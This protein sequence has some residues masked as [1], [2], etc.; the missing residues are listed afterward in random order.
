M[1]FAGFFRELD[2]DDPSDI[3]GRRLADAVGGDVTYS[4]AE[5]LHYL[6]SG[7]PIL[8]VMES[9][10][11]PLEP[12]LSVR[13]G[14]SLLTDG[15]WVWRH[16]LA[17]YVRRYGVDLPSAFLRRMGAMDHTIPDVDVDALRA[18]SLEVSARLGHT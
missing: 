7:Y 12:D 14:P 15:L 2:P 4:R 3:Y 11:D 6:E 17:H 13:G 1:E 5:V 9:T 16:D 10:P 8:D 18:F